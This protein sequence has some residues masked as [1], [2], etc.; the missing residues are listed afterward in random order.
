MAK[1]RIIGAWKLVQF[2]LSDPNGN[3]IY[4]FGKEC[5]GFAVFDKSG[6]MSVQIM[7]PQRPVFKT[8]LPTAEEIHAAYSTFTGYCGEYEV[9]EAEGSLTTKV[10]VALDPRWVGTDQLRYFQLD[11]NRMTLLT[12]LLEVAG[13]KF[14]AKLDWQKIEQ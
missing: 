14:K 8:D 11:G 1:E 7:H 3:H 9:N 5:I 4:P 13:I 2:E 10:K 6:H 12:P